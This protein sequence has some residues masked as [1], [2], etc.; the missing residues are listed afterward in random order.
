[1]PIEEEEEEVCRH[2]FEGIFCSAD[3]LSY[4]RDKNSPP[5]IR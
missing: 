2:I 3:L 5:W 1:V 4:F